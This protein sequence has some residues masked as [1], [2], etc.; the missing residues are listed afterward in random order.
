M[1]GKTD[2]GIL[3]LCCPPSYPSLSP[4]PT[5]VPTNISTHDFHQQK[6]GTWVR[7]IKPTVGTAFEES[8]EEH[9]KGRGFSM[10]S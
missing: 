8:Y 2:T 10:L 7:K 9:K 3:K 1:K 6:E 4:P 5:P